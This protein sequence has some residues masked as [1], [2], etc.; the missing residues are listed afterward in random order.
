VLSV[1]SRCAKTSPIRRSF[2]VRSSSSAERSFSNW[3]K[4]AIDSISLLR[5]RELPQDVRIRESNRF[6][7]CREDQAKRTAIATAI[8]ITG[9][10]TGEDFNSRLRM[11]AVGR[12]VIYLAWP[13]RKRLLALLRN[14]VSM[15]RQNKM[16]QLCAV[17][18][19][20]QSKTEP[21]FETKS[22]ASL[23]QALM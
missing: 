12:R 18:D 17:M 14:F 22:T 6:L 21:F 2:H 5:S 3:K 10:T 4:S 16:A 23:N 15:S 20:S 13:C 9:R 19:A 7:A 1:R 11:V 8:R